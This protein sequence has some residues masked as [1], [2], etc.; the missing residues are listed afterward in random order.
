VREVTLLGQ[1]VNSYRH[2]GAGLADVLAR[3][4]DIPGL[5][6]LRF[7]TSH[8]KDMSDAILEAVGSLDKA[9]EYLHFPPQ[10]GSDAVLDRMRR[11]YTSAQYRERTAA[12]RA[13][14]PDVAL[15]G[16]FIVGFPGET[17]QDFQQ[18]LSLLRETRFHQAFLFKYSPRSGTLAARWPDDVPDSAK[19]DRHQRL[20]AAQQEV[21]TARRRAMVGAEVEVLVDGLS[22]GDSA[23]YSGSTRQND[24]V[25]FPA[26]EAAVGQLRHVVIEDATPLT[27][28]GRLA[29]GE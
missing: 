19:R 8:P 14:I 29:E 9:C 4:N 25:V 5:W 21:D 15:A 23:N 16:D 12:A 6:R 17:E 18:T 11:G 20:L 3:L 26:R 7:T 1:N 27:L 10:S 2:G 28:I 24:I 22:K 13:M